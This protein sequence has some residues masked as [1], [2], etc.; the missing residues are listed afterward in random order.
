MDSN[1]AHH[2]H[3]QASSRN[4][5]IR[6]KILAKFPSNAYR[7]KPTGPGPFGPLDPLFARRARAAGGRGPQPRRAALALAIASV[8]GLSL[9]AS[10]CSGSSG[11]SPGS[12]NVSRPG[13][14]MAYAACMR[15]HG[16][17]DFPDPPSNNIIQR[18]S[19]TDLRS[20][21]FQAAYRACRSLN[22]SGGS[23]PP[24]QEAQVQRQMLAFARCMRSHGV[25]AFPDP[26]NHGGFR[27]TTGQI[28]P[29]SPIVSAAA[30]ACRSTLG[31]NGASGG[32]T[33]DD[34]V[35]A[36]AGTLNHK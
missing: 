30:A 19:R 13:D 3:S 35:R 6:S 14:P 4:A 36:A 25:P 17:P 34:L 32:M 22:P 18:P 11:A 16:V 15:S 5:A 2:H 24:Q 23:M 12:S 33:A 8:A 1:T 10:A 27:V 29:N 21:I 28:D 9:L 31:A 20:P 26:N 7:A